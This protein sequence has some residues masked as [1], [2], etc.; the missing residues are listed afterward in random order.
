MLLWPFYG[1][2]LGFFREV[3]WPIMALQLERH[4]KASQNLMG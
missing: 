1:L 4:L 2:S 3:S